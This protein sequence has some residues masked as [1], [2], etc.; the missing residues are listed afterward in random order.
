MDLGSILV[1]I[2]ADTSALEKASEQAAKAVNAV[3]KAVASANVVTEQMTAT[4]NKAAE[5]MQQLER[6]ATSAARAVNQ[7]NRAYTQTSVRV[8]DRRETITISTDQVQRQLDVLEAARR[9][10]EAM[11]EFEDDVYR[12]ATTMQL[13]WA[14]V[15]DKVRSGI[16]T[17]VAGWDRFRSGLDG[18]SK[19]LR[20]T[21]RDLS[22]YLTAPLILVGGL[23]IRAALQVDDALDYI[24]ESTGATGAALGSLQESARNMGRTT[25]S[26]FADVGAVTAELYRKFG[27]QG[28]ALESLGGKVLDL[29]RLTRENA[30]GMTQAWTQML[31]N[32]R[33]DASEYESS[34][35]KMLVVSQ[36]TGVG[37]MDALEAMVDLGPLLRGM[38]YGWEQ[39]IALIG[40]FYQAGVDTGNLMFGLRNAV[41]EF[42]KLQLEP[43]ATLWAYIR[44]IEQAATESEALAIAQQIF[45]QRSGPLFADAIRRDAMRI[46]ELVAQVTD[47]NGAIERTNEATWSWSQA[48]AQ[49]K[50]KASLALEPLGAKLLE[51]GERNLPGVSKSIE[52]ILNVFNSWPLSTQESVIKGFGVLAGLGP[53]LY[54]VAGALTVIKLILNPIGLLITGILAAAAGIVALTKYGEK[55]G[56]SNPRSKNYDPTRSDRYFNQGMRMAGADDSSATWASQAEAMLPDVIKNARAAGITIPEE[57]AAGLLQGGPALVKALEQLFLEADQYMPHSNAK[58]G[59]FSRLT[60]S[61]AAFVDS[62]AT[63]VLGNNS[64]V[65]AVHHVFTQVARLMP[66]SDAETGPLAGITKSGAAFGLTFADGITSETDTVVKA[67]DVLTGAL[68]DR[69]ESMQRRYGHNLRILRDSTD[70]LWWQTAEIPGAAMRY[71]T[72]DVLDSLDNMQP[73]MTL[74]FDED[75]LKLLPENMQDLLTHKVEEQTDGPLSLTIDADVYP[76]FKDKTIRGRI[77]AALAELGPLSMKFGLTLD[78]TGIKNYGENVLTLSYF[79][80]QVPPLLDQI[81]ESSNGM[82]LTL[83]PNLRRLT[84]AASDTEQAWLHLDEVV[85]KVGK[86]FELTMGGMA[87]AGQGMQLSLDQSLTRLTQNNAGAATETALTWENVKAKLGATWT[88]IVAK[89]QGAGIDMQ[90]IMKKIGTG[91][92]QEAEQALAVFLMA[93]GMTA[94]EARAVWKQFGIDVTG[95]TQRT[96]KTM[97]QIVAEFKRGVMGI[98]TNL[99]TDVSM[100]LITGQ[101]DW[102]TILSVAL[103]AMLRLL[104]EKAV[105]AVLAAKAVQEA[106]KWMWSPLG[107]L[108]IAGALAALVAI[109]SAISSSTTPKATPL[110]E[111][112]IVTKP[113]L[114]LIGEAG[115]E[116]VIP[117]SRGRRGTGAGGVTVNV[118]VTGNN[119]SGDREAD[120]LARKVAQS[121][122]DQLRRQGI[123]PAYSY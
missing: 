80:K 98:M 121:I 117:L 71:A 15:T 103:N 86:E 120:A 53:A 106:L 6:A 97:E 25:A 67:A 93:N 47:A 88:N 82:T 89:L 29:A 112:G 111:G 114:A 92:N 37:I 23:A 83:D 96:F 78:E 61:G 50:N 102:K 94:E 24:A 113:T 16:D 42:A 72:D 110:A 104:I 11:G 87:T 1:R 107:G 52:S 69:T 81:G 63:G 119:I 20:Q 34:L 99:V 35:D 115:P 7:V 64:A 105:E 75:T 33:V 26:S 62:W 101:G 58:R 122:T 14:D 56:S 39:A 60:K 68:M 38:D 13:W 55:E 116:A 41:N 59:P 66:H 18:A 43:N 85:P 4:T 5:Q 40:N 8:G 90:S 57:M 10:R 12:N 44:A 46:D 118:T 108:I 45:G 30:G 91:I 54:G 31:R 77:E 123:K 48:W 28:E 9:Q 49:F 70:N 73:K 65:D 17:V 79:L 76:Q 84:R 95:E 74:E 2:G 100:K 36:R 21:G 27:L 51:I 3:E 22:R 32:W 19:K 109:Q